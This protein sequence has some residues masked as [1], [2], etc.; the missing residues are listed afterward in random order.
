MATTLDYVEFVCGQIEGTG[1]VRYRKMFGEYMVYVDD[2]PVLPVCDNTTYV[3]I[4]PCLDALMAN[5]DK[6]FPYDGAK[7]HSI[8]DID[9]A[10]LARD[11][12]SALLPVTPLPKSRKKK[13]R[14][15]G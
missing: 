7:E 6:G 11:V 1:A 14:R 2:K 8:L 12:V 13:A 5:A 4:L 15:L 3:K 10:E 9:N